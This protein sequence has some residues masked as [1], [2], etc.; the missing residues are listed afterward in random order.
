MYHSLLLLNVLNLW[1][2]GKRNEMRISYIPAGS[3]YIIAWVRVLIQ[4]GKGMGGQQGRQGPPSQEEWAL[5]HPDFHSFQL[6]CSATN[7]K[8]E[9]R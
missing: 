8:R 5:S 9:D 1:P 3:V 4:V 6:H 7:W 2:L